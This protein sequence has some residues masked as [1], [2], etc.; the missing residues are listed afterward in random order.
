MHILAILEDFAFVTGEG[1]DPAVA[2]MRS[3]L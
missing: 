1:D 2:K 3:Y